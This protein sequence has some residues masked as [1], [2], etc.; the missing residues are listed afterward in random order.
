MN[1]KQKSALAD[2]TCF[3]NV[4]PHK[5]VNCNWTASNK[6]KKIKT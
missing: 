3:D 2:E 5:L 6:L 1:E 4:V